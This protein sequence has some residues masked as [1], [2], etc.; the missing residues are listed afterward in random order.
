MRTHI[1][2][3]ISS[4]VFLLLILAASAA[5]AA[6]SISGRVTRSGTGVPLQGISVIL[7][8][9]EDPN[10]ADK[11][12]WTYVTSASTDVDGKYH[13]DNLEPRRYRINI[14]TG[15]DVSGTHFV[16]TDLYNIQVF[17]NVGTLDMDAQLREAGFIWGYVRTESGTPIPGTIV[18]GRAEWMKEGLGWQHT[19]TDNNGLYKIWVLPS[20][21]EFYVVST[22]DGPLYTPG[23]AGYEAAI[24][25][26]LYQATIQGTRGPDFTLAGGGCITGRVVNEQGA[27]IPGVEVDPQ[28][29]MID[30]PDSKTDSLG[31]YTLT[32]TPITDKAYAYIDTWGLMPIVLDGVKY[33]SGERFVGPLTV[34]PGLP[35]TLAPDMVILKAGSIEG[36]VTDTAGT[37]IVGVEIEIHGFDVD[38]SELDRG[39]LPFTGALGQYTIDYL[40]PGEYTVTAMKDGWAVTPRSGI[41]VVSGEQTDL[42]LVM[43]RADQATSVSGRVIDFQ[44]NTCQKDSAGI[45]LPFYLDNDHSS[46]TDWSCESGIVAISSDFVYGTQEP[47]PLLGMAEIA[48]G[49][50]DYF[51][52]NPAEEVGVYQFVLPPGGV[53]GLLYSAYGTDRGDHI[54]IQDRQRWNLAE[55]ETLTDQD[56]QMPP[57]INTGVLEGVINYPA[58]TDFN[59]R[60][61]VIFAFNEESPSSSALGDAFAWVK[62]A[63]AY[64]IGHLPAG[65][66]TLRALSQGFV[67]S[68]YEGVVVSSGATTVQ[69]ITLE[70]GATLGGL[71]TDADTGLPLAGVR[72]EITNYVK[73]NVSD[74]DGAYAVSGLAAGSYNLLVSKPGYATFSGAVTVSLPTTSYDIALNSQAAS[75][76][77][78]VVDESAAAVNDAQLVAYNPTLNSFKS[79]NTVAGGFTITDLPAGDYVLGIKAL[80]Y[81]T[82]QYPPS[83]TL[84]LNPGQALVIT[85]PIVVS[86]AGPLFG[87]M[88]SVSETAGVKTL[89]VTLTSDQPLL[90]TPGIVARGQDTTAGCSIFNWQQITPSKYIASCEVA[91]GES[92]VWIDIA[93]GAVPVISG[94]PTNATFSFEVSSNLLNTS[95]TN[96]FNAIGGDSTIMGTQDQ[97]QV[98]IPPFALAGTDTQAIKLT[99]KRY[100]DPGDAATNNVNQTVSAVYDFFFEDDQVRVD[101]NHT[102]TITL[103]FENPTGM[104]QQD[105]ESD[106]KIGYFRV[107]DQQ[108]V[109]QTDPNSGISNIHINW[110]NS[111]ITFNASHFTCFAAFLPKTLPIPG[112]YDGDGDV[113]QDDL[114]V[115]LQ[116]RN[117]TVE[118]SICGSACDLDSDGTITALDARKL[119]LLCSRTRCATE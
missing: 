50:A 25:P 85:D 60:M 95:T 34:T 46:S 114:D 84:A 103:Q 109:Y 112:D 106:L 70:I 59:P 89:E 80:G 72:V 1:R 22:N 43:R 49:Y 23:L 116:D 3:I 104:S 92:L 32:N 66:Y 48:D 33:G 88:S 91:M 69:D 73:S 14:P 58:N 20:P 77:G 19:Y 28:I 45:L 11:N 29:G 90:S 74:A 96:I 82:V 79:S 117:K 51:L 56:F 62:F 35:C 15:K 26:G 101:T 21:G 18:H 76:T 113:D 53:E 107:S 24:A 6:G 81:A 118:V 9:S 27:G 97:T 40:P 5:D 57:I 110:L 16:Q 71:I 12:A 108:W 111:T 31:Y 41:V 87:S 115:L 94:N 52:P 102:V 38:G 54:I 36:V 44:S 55:G 68:T 8:R 47:F 39:E 98:Y 37:P 100:G 30:N 119:V 65:R 42:D 75:I 61:T 4:L 64:R 17:D 7:Y 13:I 2:T 63:P 10:S 67:D 83:G 86:P 78:N 99:V 105:F 93:E